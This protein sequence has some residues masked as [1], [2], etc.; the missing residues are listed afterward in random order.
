MQL[1]L[2]G[3]LSCYVIQLNK[4]YLSSIREPLAMKIMSASETFMLTDD[5]LQLWYNSRTEYTSECCNKQ[6]LHEQASDCL[7]ICL[8][9]PALKMLHVSLPGDLVT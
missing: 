5:Y 2:N 9:S 8:V 1:M 7:H 3:R 4:P 6:T